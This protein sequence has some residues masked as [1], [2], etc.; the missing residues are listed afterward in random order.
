MIY[1]NKNFEKTGWEQESPSLPPNQ[2]L[3]W[4]EYMRQWMME[5]W[6]NNPDTRENWKKTDPRYTYFEE[7]KSRKSLQKGLA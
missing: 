7:V 2:V 1:P 6:R 3:T 5:I 4:L